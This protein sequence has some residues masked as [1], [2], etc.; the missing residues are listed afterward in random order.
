MRARF[1]LALL[2]PLLPALAQ[3][4]PPGEAEPEPAFKLDNAACPDF[5]TGIWLANSQ[6]DVAPGPD[7]AIWHVTEAM[8]FNGDG[9]LEHAFASGVS[10]DEP[11]ETKTFG[12]W[13]AGPGRAEDRCV[14]SL[15]FEEGEQRTAEVL[16]VTRTSI[17][18]DGQALTRAE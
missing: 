14:V 6:Q 16:A 10:G 8:V 17:L 4:E 9:T 18:L 1:A 15:V 12:V 3:E 2:L 13:T 11:E 7:Q 5:L